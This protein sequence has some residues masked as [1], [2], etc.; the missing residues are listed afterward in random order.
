MGYDSTVVKTRD[1]TVLDGTGDFFLNCGMATINTDSYEG[2]VYFR[3]RVDIKF[4]QC[5]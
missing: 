2:D 5:W 1:I 3:L 4:Y